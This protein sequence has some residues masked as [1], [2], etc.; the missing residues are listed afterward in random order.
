MTG[1]CR[2]TERTVA[3]RNNRIKMAG[4]IVA[5]MAILAT[6]PILAGLSCLAGQCFT[7]PGHQ[8]DKELVV[9]AP[10]HYR[11]FDRCLRGV[12]QGDVVD[13]G[14]P[15]RLPVSA[16][17]VEACVNGISQQA[18]AVLR[19][20]TE[21]DVEANQGRILDPLGVVDHHRQAG[22]TTLLPA[23]PEAGYEEIGRIVNAGS[24]P[25]LFAQFVKDSGG[26]EEG[27]P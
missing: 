23:G 12:A 21:S 18:E 16:R 17:L 8:V 19:M 10:A 6:L 13:Y 24:H 1:S 4:K 3:I 27:I 2:R 14:N 20:G 9:T 5:N 15:R 25:Y 7:L 11:E 26:V 22:G